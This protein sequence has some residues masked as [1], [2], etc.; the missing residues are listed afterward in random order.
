MFS[1]PLESQSFALDGEAT[2]DCDEG[3][4]PRVNC[5]FPSVGMLSTVGVD[6]SYHATICAASLIHKGKTKFVVLTAAYCV[7]VG[8]IFQLIGVEGDIAD[9]GVTFDRD[10][11]DGVLGSSGIPN[12][13]L[14]FSTATERHISLSA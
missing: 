1:L 8:G 6:D 3:G 9:I 12:S 2:R 11:G 13:Q 7:T 14:F 5:T 4:Q 10:A